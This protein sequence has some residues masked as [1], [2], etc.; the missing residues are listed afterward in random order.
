MSNR[1]SWVTVEKMLYNLLVYIKNIYSCY[2]I[3]VIKDRRGECMVFAYHIL[4]VCPPIGVTVTVFDDFLA[5]IV[6][7]V[8]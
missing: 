6:G 7:R 5:Q 8:G 3:T 4:G 2:Y 1:Q